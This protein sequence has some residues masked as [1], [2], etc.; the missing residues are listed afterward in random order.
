MNLVGGWVF[1]SC[2]GK[3][4]AGRTIAGDKKKENKIQQVIKLFCMYPKWG[5]SL[6]WAS[7]KLQHLYVLQNPNEFAILGEWSWDIYLYRHEW[8]LDRKYVM[9]TLI[10]WVLKMKC[11]AGNWQQW[12][13]VKTGVSLISFNYILVQIFTYFISYVLQTLYQQKRRCFGLNFVYLCV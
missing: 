13:A 1:L 9:A 2:I 4:G 12:P 10:N 3:W 7:V 11:E 8:L 6:P 5:R